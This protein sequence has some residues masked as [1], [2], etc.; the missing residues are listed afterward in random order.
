M[1][2]IA[3]RGSAMDGHQFLSAA[4]AGGAT[5]AVVGGRRAHGA[6]ARRRARRPAGVGGGGGG[7]VRL[8]GSRA[9][10]SSASPAPMER[11]PP[12][13]SCATCST[14]DERRAAS[15]G[16]LGVL[17]GQ[18]R[19][20]AARR[21]RAH[22]A[23]AGGARS[24][25]LRTL[26]DDGVRAVAM[27]VSSHTLDQRRVD[28]V[29][30]DAAVFTNLTR[31]HLDY[32]GTMEAYFAAKARLVAHLRRRRHGGAQRRR[33]GVAQL[34]RRPRG[35]VAL[36][37][38]RRPEPRSPPR[39]STLRGSRH[40]AARSRFGD[41]RTPARLPLIGD[42]NVANALGAAA[43]AWALGMPPER[44]AERL[45]T[46]PQVPGRLEMRA[47]SRR[48]CCA[49]TRT[50]PTRSSARS[51]RCA[52]SPRAR[53]IVVFGCGGDRDRGK[54]PEMGRIAGARPTSPSSPAT[55]RAPRIP[56]A[57]L[58]DI[59]RGMAAR[60]PRAHRGSSRGDR[61]ALWPMRDRRDDV[62]LLAGKGHET[63]QIRGTDAAAVRRAGD[64]ARASGRGRAMSTAVPR[65]CDARS[66][67]R[68]IAVGECARRP[69]RG[70]CLAAPTVRARVDR[71]ARDRARATSSSR[72]A[73]SASMRT[74]F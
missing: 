67:G 34:L 73:A 50:R 36:L 49:T 57:I 25:V 12:S 38:Q 45:A 60:Q 30:F 48:R 17:I 13:T 19:R 61:R 46:V 44:V 1:L 24:A 9:A 11:R 5:M 26:V 55:I 59:E 29:L 22:H 8:S 37:R 31:D 65:V 40:G 64:R 47:P 14:G 70:D 3:V 35:C 18:R 21:R 56:S 7:G 58:D 39:Q 33:S 72:C 42:F 53:L 28:G 54:R 63:Y 20:A 74:T 15:I 43:T 10:T 41:Q 52:R 66:S 4:A 23:G 68:A 69:R 32:H 27:E 16:T 6:T 2:F 51:P 71:H 62:I